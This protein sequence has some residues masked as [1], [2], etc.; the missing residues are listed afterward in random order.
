[1]KEAT[2]H[3]LANKPTFSTW[4]NSNQK[5]PYSH[6]LLKPLI[7]EYMKAY[8]NADLVSCQTCIIE[9]LMWYNDQTK[10]TET[11]KPKK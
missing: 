2:A 5:L 7:P 4:I 11:P 3:Y 10:E 8:P 9:M 1:M 6:D